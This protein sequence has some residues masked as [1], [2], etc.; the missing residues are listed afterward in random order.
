MNVIAPADQPGAAGLRTGTR[1]I[2]LARAVIGHIRDAC[3]QPGELTP[4]EMVAFSNRDVAVGEILSSPASGRA[5]G[6]TTN[7]A[8]VVDTAAGR[9]LFRRGSLVFA[10]EA[11]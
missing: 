4:D 3:D 7:G 2:D 10:S 9:E 6:I 11:G 1:R 5:A 8:L